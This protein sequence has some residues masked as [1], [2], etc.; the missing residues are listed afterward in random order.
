MRRWLNLARSSKRHCPSSR[1]SMATKPAH[2]PKRTSVG[3]GRSSHKALC[4]QPG[5]GSTGALAG[6]EVGRDSGQ[7]PPRQLRKI[8]KQNAKV[9][10]QFCWAHFKRNLLGAQEVAGSRGGKRFCHE[11]LACER[12]L[13]R[14]WHRFRGRVSVRGSPPLTREQLVK[15]RFRFRRNCL[16]WGN[17]IWIAKTPKLPIRLGLCFNIT[18][19]SSPSWNRKGWSRPR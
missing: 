5:H 14:L 9:V 12:R 17:A 7:R 10:M 11:A 1:C 13:F 3:C 8:L 4:N 19:S 6:R 18:R 2:R 16:L 15:N